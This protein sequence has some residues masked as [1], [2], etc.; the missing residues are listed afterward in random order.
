MNRLFEGKAYEIPLGLME[1]FEHLTDKLTYAKQE[2]FVELYRGYSVVFNS[3]F[4][5]YIRS[6]N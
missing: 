4:S 5:R 2:N 3:E 6:E 1:R